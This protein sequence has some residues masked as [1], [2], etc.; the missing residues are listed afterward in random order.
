MNLVWD[1]YFWA[2]RQCTGQPQQHTRGGR[3]EMLNTVS[4]WP[5]WLAGT[6]WRPIHCTAAAGPTVPSQPR[7]QP[8]PAQPQ[9]AE[10]FSSVVLLSSSGGQAC[11]ASTAWPRARAA[12]SH[13][14]APASP[15]VTS[16]R[17]RCCGVECGPSWDPSVL[18]P[19]CCVARVPDGAWHHTCQ[20]CLTRF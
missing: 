17:Y 13:D 1:R 7:H 15:A 5:G 4:K 9:P 3:S 20:R 2:F 19:V 8:A 16:S 10:A 14:P 18:W 11:T 6:V 12:V